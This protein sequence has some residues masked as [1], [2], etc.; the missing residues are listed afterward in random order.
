MSDFNADDDLDLTPPPVGSQYH[1]ADGKSL[2]ELVQ[3][4]LTEHDESN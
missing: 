1:P 4:V 3:R 2:S